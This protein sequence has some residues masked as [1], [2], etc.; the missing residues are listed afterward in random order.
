MT[1]VM[2][3][4]A[5]AVLLVLPPR[6]AAPP[7]GPT[8]RKSVVEATAIAKKWRPDAALTHVSS[9][10]V[11]AD[12]SAKWWL[13]TFYSPQT[14]KSFNITIAPGTAPDTLSVPN[15]SMIPIGDAWVDSDK[16]LQVAK[17]HDLKGSS[18]SVGLV[19]MGSTG[20]PTWAVNGGFSE[21]DASVLLDGNSGAFIRRQVVSYK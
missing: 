16:A 5:A 13:Y 12:G 19:V 15:T 8:A 9:L 20:G 10:A 7:A 14:K 11:N 4:M 1:R 17:Q 6:A 2:G 3:M 18:L 21:G